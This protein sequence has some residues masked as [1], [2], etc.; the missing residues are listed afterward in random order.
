MRNKHWENRLCE[1][2][3]SNDEICLLI[4]NFLTQP[5]VYLLGIKVKQLISNLDGMEKIIESDE[6]PHNEEIKHII[7]QSKLWPLATRPYWV[8]REISQLSVFFYHTTNGHHQWNP[9]LHP[10]LDFIDQS[11]TIDTWID[12]NAYPAPSIILRWLK[13]C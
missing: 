11:Q 7:N 3:V 2:E 1:I 9:L 4:D 10:Y 8:K 6:R 5:N 12:E 13:S